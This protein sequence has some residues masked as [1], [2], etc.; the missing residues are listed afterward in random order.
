MAHSTRQKRRKQGRHAA[1]PRE[2]VPSF[3]S[4]LEALR[5]GRAQAAAAEFAARVVANPNDFPSRANHA[6]ALYDAGDFARA[7]PLFEA[8]IEEEGEDS[9]GAIPTFFSLG[10]CRLQLGDARAS[11]AATAEFLDR[12]NERHPFYLDGLENAA[13]AWEQLG[14]QLEARSLLPDVETCRRLEAAGRKAR[15]RGWPRKR[16]IETCFRILGYLG[17]RVRRPR[18]I[19]WPCDLTPT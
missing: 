2:G 4:A 6:I 3:E 10:Y 14:A 19:G 9:P 12:S 16:V 18:R 15:M 13:C 11:L 7:A 5:S 17:R 8:L 1:P